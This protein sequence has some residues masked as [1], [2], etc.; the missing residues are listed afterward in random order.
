MM[1]RIKLHAKNLSEPL[2]YE[3]ST[4]DGKLVEMRREWDTLTPNEN[5]MNGR[6]VLRINGELT[7]FD[8]YRNDIAERNGFELCSD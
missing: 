5:K 8:R 1:E 7:D 2:V 3:G 4:S 6:W